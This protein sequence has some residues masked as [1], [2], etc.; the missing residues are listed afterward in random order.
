MSAYLSTPV[1]G[2]GRTDDPFATAMRTGRGPLWLRTEDGRHRIPLHVERWCA[3]PDSADSTLVNRALWR[4]LPT[5]DIGCGPGRLV[6]A[7]QRHGL[8]ALGVDVTPAA[9]T[10]TIG[11]GGSALCRS[12]FDR[13]PGEGRWATGLLADGNLGIG[14]DPSALLC[15]VAQLLAPG[16]RLLVEVEPAEV[17][18]RLTVR[19]EDG[20]GRLGPTFPWARL[21][22]SATI[23]IAETAGFTAAGGWH[24]D[25][26]DFL[27]LVLPHA[28]N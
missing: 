4:G 21:G 19:L 3:E 2:W 23:R 9:V 20:A 10:R 5:L 16:G 12:V 1:L 8:P 7:L 24:S 15:R 13:L 18:E 6:T 25:G 14:G 17:D 27:E 11:L 22:K 26:R 28:R